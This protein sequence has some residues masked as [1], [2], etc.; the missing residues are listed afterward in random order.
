MKFFTLPTLGLAAILSAV[1]VVP[2][3]QVAKT[4]YVGVFALEV[5]MASA[6]AGRIQLYFPDGAGGLSETASTTLP[7]V[8]DSAVTLYRLPLPA[9]RYSELR[10]DPIDRAGN[11]AIETM[12][13]VAESGRVVRSIVFSEVRPTHDIGS[14][15]ERGG[16]L[17]L[18]TTPGGGGAGNRHR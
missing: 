16:R 2:F 11:V 8:P 13:F 14:L 12:R 15:H 7:L 5:R 9:G 6:A 10:L 1:V 3:L 17:E 4:S 18:G